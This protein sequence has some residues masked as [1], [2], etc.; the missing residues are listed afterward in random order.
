MEDVAIGTGLRSNVVR[1]F[2]LF[3][4]DYDGGYWKLR[5]SLFFFLE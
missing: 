2:F 1:F 5:G 4:C 3:V